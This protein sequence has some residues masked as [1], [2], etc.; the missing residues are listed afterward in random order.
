MTQ[1]ETKREVKHQDKK[2]DEM[3]SIET[4]EKDDTN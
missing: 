3:R 4:I 2:E 1:A